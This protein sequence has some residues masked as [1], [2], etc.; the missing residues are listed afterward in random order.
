[1][2]NTII[3]R[4]RF[5]RDSAAACGTS[6][7]M[8]PQLASLAGSEPIK[9]ENRL[10]RFGVMTDVHKDVIH[11]ADQ[12]LEVFINRMT[13]LRPDFVIQLGDFC[14]P[15]PENQAFLEIW[16]RFDGPRYHVLGNHDMDGDGKHRPDKAYAFTPEETMAFLGMKKRYHSFDVQGV[17]FIVLDSNEKGPEQK[18][19]Y[20]YVLEQQAEWLRQDLAATPFPTV[21]FIHHSLEREVDG[22]ANQSSIRSILEQSKLNSG[23]AKVIA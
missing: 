17:H 2:N 7:F 14:I 16:K 4:R 12:R 13:Q 6:L 20:R 11:D 5:L 21:V 8:I 9:E 3:P 1:M 19:Y 15:I 18:P 23:E 22:V 10:V